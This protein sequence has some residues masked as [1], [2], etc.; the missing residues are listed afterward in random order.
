VDYIFPI[1]TSTSIPNLYELLVNFCSKWIVSSFFFVFYE[2]LLPSHVAKIA[3]GLN[4]EVL[5]I[6][7]FS[8]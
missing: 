3:R 5:K 4:S 6:S 7:F 1:T 2:E 8:P